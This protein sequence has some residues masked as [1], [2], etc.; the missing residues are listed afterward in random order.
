M[1]AATLIVNYL[2][3]DMTDTEFKELFEVHG[4]VMQALIARNKHT[5]ESLT[6]GF[7]KYARTEDASSAVIEKNGYQIGNKKLKVSMA[8]RQT[9]DI[10]FRKLFV[11]KL[12]PSYTQDDV[13]NL[14][15]KFGE[16]IECRL[17]MESDKARSRESAFVEFFKASHCA[18]ALQMDGIVPPGGTRPLKVMN[19]RPPPVKQSGDEPT[20]CH[21]RK[22]HSLQEMEV[23]I[24]RISP[25]Q[26]WHYSRPSRVVT[27]LTIPQ[28][29][30][31]SPVY[32]GE[33]MQ[34]SPTNLSLAISPSE[35]TTPSAANP[36]PT[37]MTASPVPFSAVAYPNQ[38][39]AIC[40]HILQIVGLPPFA[41]VRV[42]FD[43]FAP[44]GFVVSAGIDTAV[45][46]TSVVTIGTGWVRM[47]G[48]PDYVHSVISGMHNYSVFPT[49]PP[50][51]IYV[52]RNT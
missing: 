39:A 38:Q 8:R 10:Q 23:D 22:A 37:C 30:E 26:A 6:Y 11:S 43:L 49:Y 21:P 9:E 19:A 16:I 41:N 51:Q 20:S 13:R 46:G 31:A 18:A 5:G 35:L 24:G 36:S 2:P 25:P 12:P 7:I 1:E 15:L 44:V 28:Y 47:Y 52:N 42:L 50:I 27:D 3:R 40:E 17:L 48:E 34:P 4:E 32:I 33:L 14:F 45:D 29:S